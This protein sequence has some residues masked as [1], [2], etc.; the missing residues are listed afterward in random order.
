MNQQNN[1]E[2]FIDLK[3]LLFKLQNFIIFSSK[4]YKILI[5]CFVVMG[6][7]GF[8]QNKDKK[9]IYTSQISYTLDEK[10]GSSS[11]VNPLSGFA[12]Q[13]GVASTNSGGGDIF[14]G[15]SLNAIF[16]SYTTIRNFIRE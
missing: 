3:Y 4:N 5:I 6:I 2:K 13:F 7:L 12:S 14:S 9:T 8:Y 16:R 15:S 10:E 11:A 1:D